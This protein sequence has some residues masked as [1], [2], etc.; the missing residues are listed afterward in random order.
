MEKLTSQAWKSSASTAMSFSLEHIRVAAARLQGRVVHTPLLESELLNEQLGGRV[1]FKPECLQYTGA[2]KFRGALNKIATLTDEQCDKGIV[3]YSSGN[4]AQG[5]AAAAKSEGIHAKIVIPQ[6]APALKI[7]NTRDYGAEV[8][9]YDRYN[10]SREQIG[11][12][13]AEREG[14]TLVPPYDDFDVMAGQGTVGLEIVESLQGM[15]VTADAVL[16]PCGG[17]GLIAGVS[18]AI[19]ALSPETDVYAV[20]PEGFD[21]T[22]RSL[23][24]GNREMNAT[25][26][27]SV[28][29]SI[30]TPQ[31]GELTF[32]V[33]QA[34]LAGGLVVTDQ[35]VAEAMQLAFS[36]LKVV[37]EPGG[38]V[39]LAALLAGQYQLAGK[40]VVVVLS[41][42]N[43]DG[44]TFQA[45]LSASA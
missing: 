4:H 26:G 39:G 7:Q 33:N 40:T 13:I 22:K 42:G 24:S 23:L 25:Q 15:G 35:Q 14:R 38:V 10:E 12:E 36:R 41:G 20:E 29:D 21:D 9:L 5:V 45:A 28:C 3:A 6:D 2:F 11:R 30:V 43:V 16:C 17:G 1:L 32:P 27:G 31:P 8:I 44:A 37:V 19:K 34:T 18:T